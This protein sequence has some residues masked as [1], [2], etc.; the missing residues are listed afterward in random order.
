MSP[1]VAIAFASICLTAAVAHARRPPAP[2]RRIK[3]TPWKQASKLFHT[4]PRWLGGDDAYS[5]PLGKGKTLWLFG[6]SF[7]R[8]KVGQPRMDAKFINNSIGIQHGLDPARAKIDF[9]WGADA[10]GGPASFFPGTQ[11][12][13]LWPG[14][15]TRAGDGLLMFMMKVKKSKPV[16]GTPG[17]L[18]FEVIGA[19]AVH[20]A[21]PTDPPAQWKR[22]TVRVSD[23]GLGVTVGSAGVMAHDGHVYAYSTK[24]G[25]KFG[26]EVYLVRWTESAAARGDLAK[27]EWWYGDQAGWRA[28]APRGQ[29]PTALMKDGQAEFTVHYDAKAKQFVQ[30]QTFGMKRTTIGIRT[31]ARPEGP[32]GA[33]QIVYKIP[34]TKTPGVFAYAGK[35][36]PWLRGSDLVLT[37]ATNT[38]DPKALAQ[39]P[40][41]YYPQFAKLRVVE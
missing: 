40:T 33:A 35:A 19:E 16:P 41:I 8:T 1:R 22:K 39:H 28:R 26:H 24:N 37:Y 10:K 34:E 20:V 13:W 25:P 38:L 30:V 32:W 23:K 2:E 12:S 29:K 3:V 36:H 18:G 9:G 15:A 5:V 17:A 14:G 21:N 11:R 6:D 4:D 31:A 7:I 27:A